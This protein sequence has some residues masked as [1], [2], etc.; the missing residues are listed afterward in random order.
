M[1]KAAQPQPRYISHDTIEELA[2]QIVTDS[3]MDPMDFGS[4]D[5]TKLAQSLGCTVEEVDFDPDTISAKAQKRADGTYLIQVSR[6]DGPKRQRF[7]IA[8][9]VSHIVLHDD[10]EFVEYR[11]P[12]SDY[13]DPAMLYKEVQ[14]NMLASALLMPKDLVKKVWEETKDIDDL[15]EI[16]KVSRS[17]AY[18]R[19]DNLQ[20]LNGD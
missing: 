6:K 3:G 17:A 4:L 14:A 9:E 7:S 20:L 11:K 8:H 16:F 13:D 18:Y 1:V 19:L 5:V 2:R 12:L 15:A 10:E